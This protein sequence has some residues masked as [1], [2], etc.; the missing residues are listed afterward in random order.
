MDPAV[1]K[2]VAGAVG[3]PARRVDLAV[4]FHDGPF[5]VDLADPL[6]EVADEFLAGFNLFFGGRVAVEIGSKTKG[7]VEFTFDNAKFLNEFKSMLDSTFHV[8]A[9]KV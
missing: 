5:A 8:S 1:G 6:T 7:E 3:R 9:K 2:F 4:R